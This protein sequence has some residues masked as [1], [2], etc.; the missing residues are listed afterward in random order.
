MF[1]ESQN[2]WVWTGPLEIIWSNSRAQVGPPKAA[3]QAQVQKAFDISKN[4]NCTA[5]LWSMFFQGSSLF[6]DSVQAIILHSLQWTLTAFTTSEAK[7]PVPTPLSR[8]SNA[9]DLRDEIWVPDFP[10]CL[11]V[12]T[13]LG[14]IW[15]PLTTTKCR[16]LFYRKFLRGPAPRRHCEQ[17]HICMILAI[18]WNPP[19]LVSGLASLRETKDPH[20]TRQSVQYIPQAHA[21]ERVLCGA[22]K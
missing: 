4:W 17:D 14:R 21:A 10:L 22:A 6:Q 5:S 19:V 18:L 11:F 12:N 8:I 7:L 15:P 1:T 20:A 2:G 9:P 13:F 16:C 3:V